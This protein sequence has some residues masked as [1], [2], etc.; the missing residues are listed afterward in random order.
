M[1]DVL[2]FSNKTT[3]DT[4]AKVKLKEFYFHA[5][6][7][8]LNVVRIGLNIQ[9]MQEETFSIRSEVNLV[10]FRI[11]TVHGF[12]DE[13]FYMGGY[14]SACSVEILSHNFSAKGYVYI[15]TAQFYELYEQLKRSYQSLSG[16]AKVGSYENDFSAELIFDGL[17][18]ISVQGFYSNE[19]GNELKFSF[20]TDQTYIKQL[21]SDLANIV[22]K[23]GDNYGKKQIRT[24]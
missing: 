14:D 15:S 1:A 10:S 16:T 8:A 21:I 6:A 20:E 12:P 4:K 9:K 18:H 7:N 17:G 24:T 22:D 5:F 13:T 2:T 11:D 3:I 23:Y 19:Y